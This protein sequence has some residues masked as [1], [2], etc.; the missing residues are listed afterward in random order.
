MTARSQKEAPASEGTT[1]AG[2]EEARRDLCNDLAALS[3]ENRLKLL[4][5]LT[6]PRYR[7]E[8]ATALGMSRQSASKHIE[9]LEER[10]FVQELQ[11][12]RESGPV[13]EYLVNPKRL[14]ALGMRVA[15]L[16]K[17]EPEGGRSQ[18]KTE[19]TMMLDEPA[20]PSP[21]EE[22]STQAAHLL[23]VTGPDAGRRFALEGERPRWTIGRDEDRSL[24]I[25][26]D[27]FISGRHAEVQLD[28]KGHAL[29]DV[30]S[31]NGTFVN[32]TK[33]PRG[34]RVVLEFGDVIGIGRTSL[35]YQPGRL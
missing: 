29:V 24:Q 20:T 32:F 16:G 19:H 18:Q 13:A 22:A 21:S 7:E 5:L 28:P 3:N 15:D 6:R 34:S 35:V 17:L 31:A 1:P 33:L 23:V 4:H 10:G 8:I 9:K 26:H 27:P 30:F 25:D 14:F 2:S 12:W 11:G